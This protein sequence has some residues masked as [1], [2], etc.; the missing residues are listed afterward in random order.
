MYAGMEPD[1]QQRLRTAFQPQGRDGFSIPVK[2]GA[3]IIR[4]QIP[5]MVGGIRNAADCQG[6]YI[7]IQPE[8]A[9]SIRWNVARLV[10]LQAA[11]S[12]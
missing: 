9:A 5:I 3:E 12:V 8:P 4:W 2:L 10:I 6:V 11:P 1:T 7:R